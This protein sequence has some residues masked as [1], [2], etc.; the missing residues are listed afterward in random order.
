M[1][2]T[3]QGKTDI[4]LKIQHE[5]MK[6]YKYNVC[7]LK[8]H[9]LTAC[10]PN[11]KTVQ[12][13]SPKKSYIL[14]VVLYVYFIY[15]WFSSDYCHWIYLIPLYLRLKKKM[16]FSIK[17]K[18]IQCSHAWFLNDKTSHQGVIKEYFWMLLKYKL[19]TP[20]YLDWRY[21][22]EFKEYSV[23]LFWRLQ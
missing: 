19:K 13:N 22:E 6:W 8:P 7:F 18:F 23:W 3:R 12:T 15:S 4:H 21:L 10:V 11:A 9:M 14:N 2:R 5:I 16:H 1:W 17:T 20:Q